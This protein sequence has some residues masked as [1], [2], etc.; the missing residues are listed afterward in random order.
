MEK[1][2]NNCEKTFIKKVNI[3]VKNWSKAKYCSAVC[4]KIGEHKLIS[5]RL[6][7]QNVA[8]TGVMRFNSTTYPQQWL[9]N[10]PEK[11]KEIKEA[12]R[13][14]QKENRQLKDAL[15]RKERL[16]LNPK[17]L[18]TDEEKKLWQKGYRVRNK[19]K[20]F[21]YNRKDKTR[22]KHYISSAV[23]R[24]HK[25]EL[26]FQEFTDVFHSECTYCGESDSR[27]VDRVNNKLGYTK[28]NSVACCEICNK[29]KINYTKE[30]FM[31]H[32]AKISN[33]NLKS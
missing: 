13:L 33:F 27:G 18:K 10:N 25:F 16:K 24:N 6:K 19:A 30:F 4:R 9:E 3:S 1:Q 23:K 11:V 12:R 14:K 7:I 31:E 5:D 32:C 29:M 20:L 26:T 8:R 21:D 2:C 17:I 22:F 28:E 15:I